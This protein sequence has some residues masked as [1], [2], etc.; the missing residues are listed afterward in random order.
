MVGRCDV[1]CVVIVGGDE[2]G[3]N[4]ARG[5]LGWVRERGGEIGEVC[6]GVCVGVWM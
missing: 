3:N 5:C 6:D 2:I 1:C 4:F